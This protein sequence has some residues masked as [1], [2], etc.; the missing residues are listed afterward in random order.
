MHQST[1][2]TN[3]ITSTISGR[4]EIEIYVKVKVRFKTKRYL[5]LLSKR[6]TLHMGTIPFAT[7]HVYNP[8][9]LHWSLILLILILDWVPLLFFKRLLI[10]SSAYFWLKCKRTLSFFS[11]QK[12]LRSC[13]FHWHKTY[14]FYYQ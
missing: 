12:Y 2:F 10:H 6:V 4:I 7:I 11:R 9:S 14:C 3:Y 8:I 13:S 5:P 1:H